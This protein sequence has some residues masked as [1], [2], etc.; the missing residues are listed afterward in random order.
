M[1]GAGKNKEKKLGE[2]TPS[3]VRVLLESEKKEKGEKRGKKRRKKRRE[4]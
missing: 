2:K 1:R 4:P 3:P